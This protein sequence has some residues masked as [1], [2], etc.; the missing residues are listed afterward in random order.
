MINSNLSSCISSNNNHQHDG[1]DE[2]DGWSTIPQKKNTKKKKKA[3][4]QQQELMSAWSTTTVPPTDIPFI[5]PSS[6]QEEGEQ[7]ILI[8]VGLPGSGK[9]TF[10]RILEQAM[11]YKYARINQDKLKT[12][13]RCVSKTKDA[14]QKGLCPIIDRFNFD[15]SQ[16]QTW[17]ELRTANSL[18][19]DCILFDVPVDEC[20]RRCQL[21]TNHETVSSEQAASVVQTVHRQFD[22]DE[23]SIIRSYICIC[24]MT[25]W[26][27][28]LRSYLPSYS[29]SMNYYLRRFFSTSFW[30]FD[31]AGEATGVVC[32]LNNSKILA[33]EKTMP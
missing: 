22:L 7:F 26:E 4:A 6:L 1:N 18:A 25:M 21:R 9:S 29:T 28:T 33:E 3:Q 11:P 23:L 20:I 32:K 12:R 16:R 13:K 31:D 24:N 14:L 15:P 8:L 30:L 17:I 2:N 10:A 5:P 27:D 19:V